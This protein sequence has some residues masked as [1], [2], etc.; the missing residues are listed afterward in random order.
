[1]SGCFATDLDALLRD[2][3]GAALLARL[4][5]AAGLTTLAACDF[6]AGRDGDER[7]APST[8]GDGAITAVARELAL[9]AM[10]E[11]WAGAVATW[12]ETHGPLR[13]EHA[14]AMPAAAEAALLRR[15]VGCWPLAPDDVP[16]RLGDLGPGA[17][18]YARALVADG[19][20]RYGFDGAAARAA[21]VGRR[22]ARASL[23]LRLTLPGIPVVV[24][25]DDGALV[26]VLERLRR[27]R[28][29]PFAAPLEPL[30]TGAAA[31]SVDRVCCFARGESLIVA[32]CV[33]DRATGACGWELPR[34]AGGAWREVLSGVAYELPA[35]ATLAGVLGAGGL[36]V[37]V[38]A[39]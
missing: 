22:I 8:G 7:L 15:L 26:A 30:A 2:P 36:A 6:L 13:A 9:P 23:V 11:A 5:P 19:S 16:A 39:D 33:G 31:A 38:P 32:V 24:G 14:P 18:A 21:E 4:D 17:V 35:G 29:E 1:M 20:F 37:L 12:H 3:E 28:P 25:D 34:W 10:A 27:E